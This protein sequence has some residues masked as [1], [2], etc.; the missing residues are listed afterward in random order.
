[1]LMRGIDRKRFDF[2]DIQN[3]FSDFLY[4]VPPGRHE[5]LAMNVQSGHLVPTESMR[6]YILEA[7]LQAGVV[8]RLVE[9][10]DKWRASLVREKDGQEVA[11]GKMVDHQSSFGKP[12]DWK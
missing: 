11:I 8:Y 9:D 12:C 1:M 3:P 10:K 6:C 5:F 7:D 4:A 2:K